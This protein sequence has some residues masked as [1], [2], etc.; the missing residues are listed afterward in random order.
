MQQALDPTDLGVPH[1]LLGII[2]AELIHMGEHTTITREVNKCLGRDQR[3]SSGA[4]VRGSTFSQPHACIPYH[5]ENNLCTLI[6]LYDMSYPKKIS[7]HCCRPVCALGTPPCK[8]RSQAHKLSSRLMKWLSPWQ[9]SYLGR[10]GS[11]SDS[12]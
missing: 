4:R 11:L 7:L 10:S 5:T 2:L 1:S 3:S 8:H 12:M 6:Y 9:E